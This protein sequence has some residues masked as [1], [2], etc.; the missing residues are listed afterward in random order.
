MDYFGPMVNRSAR[1][2]G[3]ARGGQIMCSAD[4]IREVNAK[5]NDE[6]PDTDAENQPLEAIDA[7]R[8]MGLSVIPVGEVRLKG[9]EVPEV[10]SMVFPKE[11]EGRASLQEIP[12]DPNSSGSRVPFSVEQMRELGFLCLRLEALATGRMFRTLPTLDRKGSL[13]DDSNAGDIPEGMDN[14]NFLFG[15]PALLLPLMNDKTS[16]ND[17]M[18]I[19]DSLAGRIENAIAG[20]CGRQD[21][22]DLKTALGSALLQ[23]SGL[24][25]QTLDTILNVLK[26]L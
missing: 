17:L 2:Q 25:S 12:E 21:S 5:L 16:D 15:D 6:E 11:L 24:D 1:I 19:M 22:S 13:G 3:S 10:L 7:I 4:V 18:L 26:N 9:L 23:R 20:L 14:P 8:R